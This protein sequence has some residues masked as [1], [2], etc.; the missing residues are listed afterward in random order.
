M[1]PLNNNWNLNH[2]TWWFFAE[3]VLE[4]YNHVILTAMASQITSLTIVFSNV[5]SG[6][7]ERKHQSSA[8]LA[9]VREIHRWPV[10]FPHKWPVTGKMFLFD[11]VIM[12]ISKVKWQSFCSGLHISIYQM[13]MNHWKKHHSTPIVNACMR[14]KPMSLLVQIMA[15][16]LVGTEP[17]SETVLEYC[18]LNPWEWNLMKS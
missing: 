10:N 4:H 8:S 3:N 9:F 16:H 6:T 11:D 13:P 5:Y 12:E 18:W 17:L 7:Y 15:C 2:I 14:R 1:G